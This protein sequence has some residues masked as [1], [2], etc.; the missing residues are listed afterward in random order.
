VPVIRSGL[1]VLVGVMGSL[2]GCARAT[3][4]ADASAVGPRILFDSAELATARQHRVFMD[5]ALRDTV[6]KNRKDREL[7]EMIRRSELLRVQETLA[8]LGY[9]NQLTGDL[10][11]PTRLAIRAFEHRHGLPVTGDPES[12]EL[13]VAIHYVDRKTLNQFG[14][15]ALS[16]YTDGWSTGILY[17]K[18]TWVPGDP[19]R[20]TSEISC[21]RSQR[22]CR[23]STAY[24]LFSGLY[25]GTI[26]YN[27]ERWDEDELVARDDELCVSDVLTINRASESVILARGSRNAG[28]KACQMLRVKYDDVVLRL[29]DGPAVAESLDADALK[30]ARLGPSAAALW[31][32]L[33]EMKK[34]P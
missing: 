20:Q 17:A 25:V 4:D 14:L 19:P 8:R 13:R 28:N 1:V 2:D 34:H 9:G 5:S 31:K 16:L 33:L 26:D 6:Q 10:D 3:P 24:L 23:E 32:R 15:P 18:G 12:P 11:R 30:Y 21:S 29:V 22:T 7:T 27:V